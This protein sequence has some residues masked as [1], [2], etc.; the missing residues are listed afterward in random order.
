[1]SRAN[2]VEV[3]VAT[4]ADP[5]IFT[6]FTISVLPAQPEPG[7]RYSVTS[8]YEHVNWDTFHRFVSAN[9][10][11]NT[12]SDGR[13]SIRQTAE[14]LYQ[15]GY[16]IA[17]FTDHS[18][19]NIFPNRTLSGVSSSY[20]DSSD[21]ARFARVPMTSDRVQEMREGRGRDGAG[22]VFI[23]GSNEHSGLQF[24]D[25]VQN[26]RSHHVNAFFTFIPSLGSSH[27]DS[28]PQALVQRME[29]EARGGLA[30]INHVGRYTG[31][32]W[33]TPW[34]TAEAISNNS[35][36]FMPYARLFLGS[37]TFNGFEII[38]KFDT[39]TQADRVLW[40][41]VLSQTM[42]YGVPAW[43][44]SDDDSHSDRSIGFSYNIMLMPELSLSH[45][46]NA[47]DVGSFFAF[48]RVDRQYN[49]YAEGLT[50]WDWPGP[51]DFETEGN[52]ASN[53]TIDR[54]HRSRH[55]MSLPV[56]EITRID[57]NDAAQTIT[58]DAHILR[59]GDDE[60][61]II[62]NCDSGEF[63]IAWYADGIQIHR[64]KTLDLNAHQLA[65]YSYVRAAVVAAGPL[66]EGPQPGILNPAGR[67][68]LNEF[69][70]LRH[71][72]YGVLYT[73]PFEI[74]RVGEERQIP[75]LTAISET[76]TVINTGEP[77]VNRFGEL[78]TAGVEALSLPTAIRITTDLCEASRPR[79]ATINWDL[80]PLDS[81]DI[82][83]R[84]THTMT[85]TGTVM[86]PTGIKRVT[87]TNNIPLTVSATLVLVPPCGENNCTFVTYGTPSTPTCD[88]RGVQQVCHGCGI[89]VGGASLGHTW[90]EWEVATPATETAAGRMVRKCARAN[91]QGEQEQSIPALGVTPPPP[92]TEDE[93]C[94]LPICVICGDGL[95]YRGVQLALRDPVE[96][97]ASGDW[98]TVRSSVIELTDYNATYSLRIDIPDG[99]TEILQFGLLTEGGRFDYDPTNGLL[100][101][102]GL[103]RTP[104]TW[105]DGGD[106]SGTDNPPRLLIDSI[107]ING[108]INATAPQP[109]NRGG[110]LVGQPDGWY[111]ER[112]FINFGMF[113][114]WHH[115]HNSRIHDGRTALCGC[116]QCTEN[117]PAGTI[118][119][120]PFVDADGVAHFE[121]TVPVTAFGLPDGGLINFI[122]VTFTVSNMP[123]GDP[124]DCDPENPCDDCRETSDCECKNCEECGFRGGTFGLGNLRN[125]PCDCC[126]NY[127][128][129]A[130]VHDA[131][132]ILR[133][134]LDLPTLFDLANDTPAEA[135]RRRNAIIASNIMNRAPV[136]EDEE[137]P[138]PTVF[139]AIAILRNL[140]DL[141]NKYAE[142]LAEFQQTE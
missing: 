5:S 49:V 15:L 43:G 33:E 53:E 127:L 75:N 46:R 25:I 63:F 74:Q 93:P 124:C 39:E 41:N 130:D 29:R 104:L 129:T 72:G 51:E 111:A 60:P 120:H 71:R 123:L 6:R 125:R 119:A 7:V 113:N 57:V 70:G 48:S 9:H 20:A 139:D 23:P 95:G 118:V 69:D 62:D 66:R 47:M 79:F 106:H 38:N 27:D 136:A 122:E 131:I 10:V 1:M 86:L 11:H 35:A 105:T 83:N 140:L 132:Q 14:V 121:G 103:R 55:A 128:A 73:Q 61:T 107:M 18:V 2:N 24:R 116:T 58:I 40:D 37:H 94:G 77:L 80:S 87:N 96:D 81:F 30:R 134:L 4:I 88:T 17:G 110:T 84:A 13:S 109:R 85:V 141:P 65:I 52:M 22:L 76:V 114:G 26:P 32:Q 31:A 16:N 34:A 133:S 137:P 82:T 64:G 12:T 90:G 68:L 101:F 3:I 56:P 135:A 28:N 126:F 44:Y 115:D 97:P 50:S 91:C 99:A 117:P 142:A 138:M 21:P 54:Y 36:N 102:T 19:T 112:G 100:P 98:R 8:P 45:V 78:F 59:R 42:P 89:R 92:C 67:P 108:T